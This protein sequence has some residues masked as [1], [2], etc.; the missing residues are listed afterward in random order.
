MK[1]FFP[2][3]IAALSFSPSLFGF[4]KDS[5][6]DSNEFSSQIEKSQGVIL[7]VE[8]NDKGEENT[9]SASLKL[10]DGDEPVS[11]NVD[12]ASIFETA[13][14]AS[15]QPQVDPNSDSSTFF[16]WHS[17]RGHGWQN[18]YYYGHYRPYYNHYGYGYGYGYN[19]Y[20]RN[21][22]N[23]GWNHGYR[24]YYYPRYW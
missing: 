4:E 22:W 14:D 5:S 10:Y 13:T 18:P 12:I 16:G 19:G 11:D 3:L 21:Y 15:N 24:Y 7:R 9:D 6:A 2:I 17:Y 20:H 1:I 8:I 23:R